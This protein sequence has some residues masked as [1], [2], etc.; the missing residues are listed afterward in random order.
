MQSQSDI[1]FQQLVQLAKKLPKNQWSKLK[2]EVENE[3]SLSDNFSELESFL[4]TAPTF[5]KIKLS[6]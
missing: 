3:K 4:L 5:T 1:A 2:D 6:H